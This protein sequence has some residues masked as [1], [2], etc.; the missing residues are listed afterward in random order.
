MKGTQIIL[1]L[2]FVALLFTGCIHQPQLMEGITNSKSVWFLSWT[3]LL[4]IFF[5]LMFLKGD[6]SFSFN[7]LDLIVLLFL[8]YSILN[9]CFHD[10]MLLSKKNY[11]AFGLALFYLLLRKLFNE[12]NQKFLYYELAFLALTLA[13]VGIAILQWY[14]LLPSF[15]NYFKITGIFFNPGPFAI[16]LAA[17]MV[18]ALAVF[19]YSEFKIVRTVAITLFL[20]G[21]PI[22]IILFSRAAWIGAIVA[23]AFILEIKYHILMRLKNKQRTVLKILVVVMTVVTML[24][25]YQLFSLKRDSANGRIVTW[26][27]TTAIIKDSYLVGVG[28][29]NFA[30]ALLKY[31]SRYFQT[32]PERVSTE[33]RLVDETWYAFNDILQITSELGIIGFCL[34]VALMVTVIRASSKI[35]QRL[36]SQMSAGKNAVIVGST[37][38][39]LSIL[40]SCMFSY[41]LT[42]LPFKVLLYSQVAFLSSCRNNA[43]SPELITVRVLGK[44]RLIVITILIGTGI[45]FIFYGASTYQGYLRW[46]IAHTTRFPENSVAGLARK[47]PVLYEDPLFNIHLANEL[48]SKAKYDSAIAILESAK[49]FCAP[50]G[51]YYTLG[52][53]YKLSNE[54]EKAEEQYSFLEFALPN[55]MRP[56]FMLAKLYYETRQTSKW[57]EK[58]SELLRFEPKIESIATKSMIREIQELVDEASSHE[59]PN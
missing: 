38:L 32:H 24:V 9:S 6:L 3:G 7:K 56:K 4:L 19:F 22:I 20:I 13:Q 59:I 39:L 46:R 15:N 53:A 25:S 51:L 37:A 45:H 31:Q 42:L 35:I 48:I 44:M 41:P 43:G 23:I 54:N 49:P 58:A 29:G 30:A 16:Y 26:R 36:G 18:F 28:P 34:I 27:L 50:K 55:Q 14:D 52:A 2:I 21:L 8:L 40:V 57:K 12:K 33:G 17:L 10:S 1:F 11:E 5:G 47:Y